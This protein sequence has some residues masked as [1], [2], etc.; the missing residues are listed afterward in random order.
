MA[1]ITVY[2]VVRR[3]NSFLRGSMG[4][5]QGG[6]WGAE[7][8]GKLF[9]IN[10]LHLLMCT[11]P[12]VATFLESA[13]LADGSVGGTW[14]VTGSLAGTS[15]FS[16]FGRWGRNRVRERPSGAKALVLFERR[17]RVGLKPSP[18]EKYGFSEQGTTFKTQI[19]KANPGRPCLAGIGL[20]A[21]V[22]GTVL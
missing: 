13:K 12:G 10:D 16:H 7:A 15:D 18:Q 6:R 19:F 9:I 4:I 20:W 14:M 3:V 17:Q 22:G 21:L 5:G 1:L 2:P 11:V 8:Y